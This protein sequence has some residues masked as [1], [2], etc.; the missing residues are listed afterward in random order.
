M[1]GGFEGLLG[2]LLSLP[3]A[4]AALA[5]A[6]AAPCLALLKRKTLPPWAKALLWAL[7]ALAVLL[8]CGYLF[9]ALA[10][11]GNA[12]PPAGPL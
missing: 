1:T 5:V 7:F 3:A 4:I 10:C 2:A 12:H 9:L 6:I 8:L 11:G